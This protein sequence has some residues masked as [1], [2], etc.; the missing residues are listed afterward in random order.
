MKPANVKL[1]QSIWSPKPGN[2]RRLSIRKPKLKL[3]PRSVE[4]LVV[5]IAI[6]DTLIMCSQQDLDWM[7][8]KC[9]PPACPKLST[10]SCSEDWMGNKERVCCP[11]VFYWNDGGRH[12]WHCGIEL[13][14]TRL[15]WTWI[16]IIVA[17]SLI[18]CGLVAPGSQTSTRTFTNSPRFPHLSNIGWKFKFT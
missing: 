17:C 8:L 6:G 18:A 5:A 7:W 11:Q 4:L 2:I 12:T 1:L 9:S 3:D 10:T 13:M 16:E 14:G 15:H